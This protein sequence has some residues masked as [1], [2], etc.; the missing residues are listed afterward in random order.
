LKPDARIP[1]EHALSRFTWT[2]VFAI[3]ACAAA[4]ATLPGNAAYA[5]AVLPTTAALTSKASSWVAG[6]HGGYNW[7][8]GPLV[9]GFETDL[10]ATHLAPG[11]SM[12]VTTPFSAAG[13]FARASSTIDWYGTFRGRG[14]FA[15]GPL[16]VFGTAGLAYGHVTLNS[17]LTYQG[18]GIDQRASSVRLG[19]TGGAGAELMLRP[20]LS[21]T[22][23][24]SYVDLGNVSLSGATAVTPAS[25]QTATAHGQFHVATV[26]FSWRFPVAGSGGP[27]AGGYV[28][29]QGGGA[30]G[31]STD[32]NY[33]FSPVF[34]ASDARLKRDVEL[35][36]RRDDGLGLYRFRYQWSDQVYVGVMAQ[37]VALVHPEAVA[38]DPL[39]GMLAVNYAR[40]GLRMIALPSGG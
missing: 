23:N 38:R 2:S 37:E 29:A 33:L 8:S 32:A 40:L 36:G 15:S 4:A 13:D 18:I 9:Y 21:L 34:F 14:G 5:G 31:Q 39:T 12:V 3:G 22:F 11:A 19:W 30:M 27:W 20:D 17:A 25:T 26:G 7:Q 35:V 10:S 1:Q 28:G 16:F 24:Y 6:G